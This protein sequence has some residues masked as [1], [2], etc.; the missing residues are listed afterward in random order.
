MKGH[1]MRV[2]IIHNRYR[3]YGGEEKIV[4]ELKR[5]L[6]EAGHQ[7]YLYEK[8]SAK[9]S[10]KNIFSMAFM[11]LHSFIGYRTKKDLQRIVSEFKPDI[12]HVHNVFPI[13][14]TNVYPIL[15]Q[16]NV[17]VVHTLHNY[18]YICANGLFFRCGRPCT[19]CLEGIS[20]ISVAKLKC[21]RDSVFQSFWYA[22]LIRRMHKRKYFD[23]IDQF[24]AL[25]PFMRDTAIKAGLHKERFTIVPNTI[26]YVRKSEELI[27]TEKYF[28]AIGRLSEE[29][30]FDLVINAANS[31]PK[32]YKII[33]AGDGPE[34]QKLYNMALTHENVELIGF[35]TGEEKE[36]LFKNAIGLI[37]ASTFYDIFP[38]VVLE[39]YSYGIPVVGSKIGGLQYM[40]EDHITGMLFEPGNV[41]SLSAALLNMISL[42]EAN[43]IL[44]QNAREIYEKKYSESITLNQLQCCYQN[45]ID[46]RV[47]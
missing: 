10:N 17:P 22:S 9:I 14:S 13:I 39:A 16:L 46:E 47:V 36:K 33:I 26:A 5:S 4:D 18:R 38:T 43:V 44:G 20:P 34:K 3:V 45:V 19:K 29:K 30:G 37:V 35:V 23:N 25:T 41:E 28:L 7:V 32:G 6:S 42:Q 40:I 31:L 1:D 21:Y 2:L 27:K 24:I 15:K 8:D 11:I 12:A